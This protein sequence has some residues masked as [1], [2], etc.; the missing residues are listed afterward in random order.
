MNNSV[1]ILPLNE[2]PSRLNEIPQPA[3]KL[4]M[5]GENILEKYPDY[6]YLAVVGSRA[7]TSYG[8]KCVDILIESLRGL[9]V[10]IVSGFAY[11]IDTAAHKAAIR[12]N[13]PTVAVPG[14]GLGDRVIYPRENT[15]F[16]PEFLESGGMFISEY[17]EDKKSERWMFPA[18]N[19]IMAGLCHA[20]LIIEAEEKSGTLI[21]ARLA[22]DYNRD[23]LVVPGNI[24]SQNSLG[25]NRLIHDGATPITCGDDLREALGFVRKDDEAKKTSN[26]HAIPTVIFSNDTE[27]ILYDLLREPLPK[28]ELFEKSGLSI[29]DFS[30]TLSM[31]ELS[32]L[33]EE[34]GG[35][36]WRV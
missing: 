17:E 18:R 25:T 32:G 13:L 31:M 29:T 20:V 24:T 36:V 9:P 23:V 21:T 26:S 35:E 14:S 16:V 28:D 22:L 11:G 27:R 7:C 5:R 6:R 8:K 33:I 10:V 4:F 15:S 19:R 3:K 30:I 1:Y 12:S 2:F 34:K